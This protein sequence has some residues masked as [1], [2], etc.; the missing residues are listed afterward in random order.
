MNYALHVPDLSIGMKEERS[1]KLKEYCDY[2]EGELNEL[3]GGENMGLLN[4][5]VNRN[6]DK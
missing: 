6:D 3:N 2:I 5:L 1:E 4:S